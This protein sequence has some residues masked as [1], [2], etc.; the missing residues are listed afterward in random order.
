MPDKSIKCVECG[1]EFNFT[2]GEQA[3]YTER[4]FQEPRRCKDCRQKAKE[5]REA[6]AA[7]AVAKDE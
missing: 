7:A 5:R 1:V 2:E 4:G 3:F 6:R